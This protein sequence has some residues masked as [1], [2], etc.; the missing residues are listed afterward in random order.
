[1]SYE[2]VLKILFHFCPVILHLFCPFISLYLRRNS[3]M[4]HILAILW[5]RSTETRCGERRRPVALRA[6][7]MAAASYYHRGQWGGSARDMAVMAPWSRRHE[8]SKRKHERY[9]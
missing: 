8:I 2:F 4:L 3:F 7:F 1:M 9:I 5:M 6:N